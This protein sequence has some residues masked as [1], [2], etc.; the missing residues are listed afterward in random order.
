[1]AFGALAQ[2]NPDYTAASRRIIS[3]SF[4]KRRFFVFIN[5]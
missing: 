4:R 5:Q 2:F 1:M 3:L